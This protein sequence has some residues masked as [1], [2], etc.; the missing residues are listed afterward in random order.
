[1]KKVLK[2][3]ILKLRGEGK[4][5]KEIRKELGCT[6]SL[7]SYYCKNLGLSDPNVNRKP[8]REEIDKIN[9]LYSEGMQIAK[10][11]KIVG[12]TKGTVRK[13]I[14]GDLRKRFRVKTKSEAVV[15]WRRN[16]KEKLVMY[17][18]GRCEKCGYNKCIA[19]LEFHH[20][21][22]LEKD[23]SI[24]GKS[25]GFETLKLEVDKCMLLCANCHKEEHYRLKNGELP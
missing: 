21:N 15:S 5:Y 23:F 19:A 1:M 2:E 17:K 9:L 4:L 13:Y 18:G 12:F 24:S 25:W 14:E 20:L 22:P 7:I 11:V 10:I 6:M 16:T 8:T 3:E